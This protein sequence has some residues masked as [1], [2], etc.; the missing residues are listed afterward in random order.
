VPQVLLRKPELPAGIVELAPDGAWTWF[1]DERAIWHQGMLYAG[2]VSAGGYTGVSRYDPATGEAKA[3]VIGSLRA[4]EVDDH[5]NTAFVSRDDGRLLAIYSKHGTAQEFYTRVSLVANPAGPDDWAPEQVVPVPFHTTYANA[6]QLAA[7]RGKIF[8]FHRGYNWNPTLSLSENGG[9][10][11]LRPVHFIAAG[12]NNRV[13]PYVR[14]A[15]NNIDRIDLAYTD[16]HPRDLEN[17]I[18]HL[19]YKAGAV[20]RT[21]GEQLKT[22]D[23]LPL[24]HLEGETGSMVYKY[25][26]KFGRGWIWDVDYDAQKNP[27]CA[28]QTRRSDVTG[29]GWNHGRIYYHYAVWTGS[30]WRSTFIAHGGRALYAREND[31]GGGMAIDPDDTRVVYISTNAASPF[32][33]TNLDRVPFAK[34]E[35]YEIWRGFTADHGL[36]FTWTPV[37]VDSAEDNLRPIVPGSHGDRSGLLWFRGK[38]T[39]Y[40]NYNT[41]IVALIK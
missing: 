11:W 8:L 15:S 28:F 2:Y 13:R 17:S 26:P 38:Y 5:N 21:N 39:T 20:F 10:T 27:V 12:K 25:A 29:S 33:L 22:L 24:Q 9:A 3:Y 32:D 36:T 1:N 31:Y 16:G 34:N 35:R 41:R 40:T 14:L 23:R 37:T 4:K 7:E 6:Y 18:Y 19:Y 30:E